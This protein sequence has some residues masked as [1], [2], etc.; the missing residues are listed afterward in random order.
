MY[1]SFK[2][3]LIALLIV[4][5]NW[6]GLSAVGNTVAM[7]NDVES[8][9][10]NVLEAGVI[11]FTLNDNGFDPLKS[12]VS[13]GPGDI[14]RKIID[15]VPDVLSNPL[16]YYASS[17]NFSGDDVFCEGLNVD[18]KFDD[19][20]KYGG[21]TFYSSSL[22]GF[23]T[24]AT[25]SLDSWMY[26][27]GA[28]AQNF[29]NKVCEFDVDYN[30][31][32]TR[33]EYPTYEQGGFSDTEKIKNK[34]SSWGFRI[35]K[36]YYDVVPDRG[37]EGDNEWVEIYNQTNID[38][39]ISGWEICDNSSCDVLPQTAP[40][41][42]FGFGV[43][44]AS[45][46]TWGFWN[47]PNNIRKIVL[48]DG[49]I[50]NRLGNSEDMLVLKRP[51]GVIVDQMNWGVPNTSWNN[52]NDE[53][54]N[55]GVVDVTEGNTLARVP[56][57]YDTDQPSDWKEL[58]PPEVDLI[59]PDEAGSYTWYW[60]QDYNIEW[61][62][63]NHNGDDADL[64]IDISYIK[65]INHDGVISDGDIEY[66]VVSNTA[67]DGIY[68]WTVY[69]GFVGYI[70]VKLVAIG[71]ENPMLND[72]AISGDIW[73]PVPIFIDNTP[74][75]AALSFLNDEGD[76][77]LVVGDEMP[78]ENKEQTTEEQ[79]DEEIV[80]GDE[81]S[82]DDTT[83]KNTENTENTEGYSTET[84]NKETQANE[85]ESTSESQDTEDNITTTEEGDTQDSDTSSE[86]TSEQEQENSE[87][88]ES[89]SD[90]TTSASTDQDT[91]TNKEKASDESLSSGEEADTDEEE[92]LD[93]TMKKAVE[94]VSDGVDA[95][96]EFVNGG[97]DV[98]DGD[99]KIDEVTTE[100][101]EETT[102]VAEGGES[103]GA[104]NTDDSEKTSQDKTSDK[105]STDQDTKSIEDI[106]EDVVDSTDKDVQVA[107]QDSDSTESSETSEE[108]T[109]TEND[110]SSQDDKDSQEEDDVTVRKDVVVEIATQD[111][112]QS[113]D[114]GE[115]DNSSDDK[116]T[117][118]QDNSGPVV[119]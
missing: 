105:N 47:I 102:E 82:E 49:N 112:S 80:A 111:D 65:D 73:D 25:T 68:N 50:G 36:V 93:E 10:E 110:D 20:T 32:Q 38:L 101:N 1:K 26:E 14:T 109:S 71:P 113:D 19:G 69:P 4:G 56:S 34:I 27:F 66:P 35:N 63:I 91:D 117:D 37:S 60:D 39:D 89:S 43:I 8:S 2:K 58:T 22:L 72:V 52:H 30:G 84:S 104:E 76:G 51:D 61:T 74:D 17:T 78:S 54:W 5:L 13:M 108:D 40:I 97:D 6:T 75:T 3:I 9:V 7:F 53:L 81:T 16:Q 29:Q 95:V 46:T 33:H 87:I 96:S 116:N 44:T 55:P 41:P 114:V 64:N 77:D 45:T 42:A 31:W 11:D 119:I 83:E 98:K 118:S 28:G 99:V 21:D 70:W 23:K 94:V 100:E 67:N 57:G 62:A 12:A 106:Q 15:V 24:T 107:T 115:S 92:E 18:L 59:Y 90:E 79:T 85:D 48:S 88:N 86:E 103:D